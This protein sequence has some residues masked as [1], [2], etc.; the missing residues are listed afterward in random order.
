MNNSVP[1]TPPPPSWEEETGIHINGFFTQTV[2][3]AQSFTVATTAATSYTVNGK[4]IATRATKK[5][6]SGSGVWFSKTLCKNLADKAKLDFVRQIESKQ[7]ITF[8][9]TTILFTDPSK[10]ISHSS[11]SKTVMEFQRSM[12]KYGHHEV[13]TNVE[14]L[15]LMVPALINSKVITT[16]LLIVISL[17]DFIA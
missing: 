12:Y 7:Q 10:L 3:R 5:I 1:H 9:A 2:F 6:K 17:I 15:I 16:E 14:P 13:S 4:V 8:S 11:L